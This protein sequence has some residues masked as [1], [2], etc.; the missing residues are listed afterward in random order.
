[1][2]TCLDGS[3]TATPPAAVAGQS[4]VP[5]ASTKSTAP[6]IPPPPVVEPLPQ[7]VEDFD[8]IVNRDVKAFVDVSQ[9]IGELAAEQV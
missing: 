3:N 5:Q 4:P 1:M 8:T 2:A 9:K 6:S 7:A